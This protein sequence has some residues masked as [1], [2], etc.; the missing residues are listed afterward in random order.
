MTMKR[1][2]ALAVLA[3]A[4]APHAASAQ[5]QQPYAGFED[6]SIKALSDQQVADLKAG[7]GMGLALA[8]ELNGY[9][10]PVHVLELAEALG[11]SEAQRAKMQ[12]LFEAMKAESVPLGEKLIVEEAALDR[13][14]ARKTITE[15]SLVAGVQAIGTMQAALRAAH[16][17]Y[18]L[19]TAEALTPT[20]IQ[21]YAEL[22]GYSG[23]PQ[24]RHQHGGHRP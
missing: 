21:R 6:R 11:L 24:A 17:K 3:F 18:H 5:A 7:R 12:A 23:D 10:G 1:L 8:A 4:M 14:F 22:R 2:A 19:A 13:E 20:Q 9:P 15:T 16:L